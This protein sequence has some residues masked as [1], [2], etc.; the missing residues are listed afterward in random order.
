MLRRIPGL[1][2]IATCAVGLGGISAVPAQAAVTIGAVTGTATH[3]TPTTAT[4]SGTATV[5]GI[6]AP[7][8]QFAFTFQYDTS[9]KYVFGTNNGVDFATVSGAP[10]AV[11]AQ[12]T[13][14]TPNRT[15]HFRLAVTALTGN[16]YD[17]GAFGTD[18]TFKT[19]KAGNLVLLSNK[20][21]V[22]KGK[23]SIGLKCSSV[24][25]CDGSLTITTKNKKKTV[26]CVSI[27]SY[28]IGAGKKKTL[29][30]KISK[31]CASLLKK[32]GKSGLKAK[33]SAVANTSPQPNLTKNVTLLSK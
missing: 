25:F 1:A 15:Y 20:I 12:A 22:H 26:T 2:L 16:Y 3:I 31:T 24:V 23:A 8:Q 28:K 30:G 32:A 33:L 17:V 13:D 10:L 4:L 21:T 19:P 7:G 11:S 14:L 5:S 29:S 9:T 6:V 18:V 27:A